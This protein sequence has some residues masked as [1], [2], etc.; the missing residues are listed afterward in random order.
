VQYRTVYEVVATQ[1]V[2]FVA[3]GV[4][5]LGIGAAGV[6]YRRRLESRALR[7]GAFGFLGFAALWVTASLVAILGS[8]A[9]LA[10]ALHEG[11]CNVVEGVIEDFVP[12]PS[13]GRKS[14]SFTVAGQRF[15]YSDYVITAGFHQSASH[16]GPIRAGMQVRIHHVGNDIARLEIDR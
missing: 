13:E 3:P 2:W 15:E 7:I 11:R 1:D 10:A 8:S 16:G 14:E 9:R 12:A 6:A 5:F 4:L